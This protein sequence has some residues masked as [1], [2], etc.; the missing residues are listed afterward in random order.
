VV[1]VLWLSVEGQTGSSVVSP[2]L[3]TAEIAKSAEKENWKNFVFFVLLVVQ[4]RLFQPSAFSPRRF[5]CPVRDFGFGQDHRR[6]FITGLKGNA[7][8]GAQGRSHAA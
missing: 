1:D 5:C 6:G 7:H 2:H 3:L 8:R 4:P